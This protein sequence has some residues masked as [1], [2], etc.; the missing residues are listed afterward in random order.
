M[1]ILFCLIAD[2]GKETLDEATSHD[3]I[4]SNDNQ[5]DTGINI[6]PQSFTYR[7]EKDI[8]QEVSPIREPIINPDGHNFLPQTIGETELVINP[9]LYTSLPSKKK[10]FST[11][12]TTDYKYLL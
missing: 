8:T 3:N 2:K 11:R 1:G 4:E 5:S 7:D 9:D 12:A 10:V 6:N